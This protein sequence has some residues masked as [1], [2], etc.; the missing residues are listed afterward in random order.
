[1]MGCSSRVRVNRDEHGEFIELIDEHGRPIYDIA[2]PINS[3]DDG[4]DWIRQIAEKTWVTKDMVVD[5]IAIII[6][7]LSAGRG[8]T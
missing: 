3:A 8:R 4:L 6:R 7:D 5:V 2:L 1:M